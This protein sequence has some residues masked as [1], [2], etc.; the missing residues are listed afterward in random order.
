MLSALEQH[1]EHIGEKILTLTGVRLGESAVRDQRIALSCSKDGA[2]CGQGWFQETTP[3]AIADTLAPLLHWRLCHVSDW[4]A[5]WAPDLGF[6]TMDIL[7]VYGMG[8]AEGD[9][10]EVG[11]R[12]GCVGCN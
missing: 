10:I 8:N 2:E 3:E 11:A 5:L 12:T 4:L 6:P 7:N 9:E 1:H